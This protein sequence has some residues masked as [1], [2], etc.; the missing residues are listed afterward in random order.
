MCSTACETWC[1]TGHCLVPSH[2]TVAT[3][4]PLILT[5][6]CAGR[7][8]ESWRSRRFGSEAN[9]IVFWWRL[10]GWRP[11]AFIFQSPLR[12]ICHCWMTHYRWHLHHRLVMPLGVESQLDGR[13]GLLSI[14]HLNRDY[15]WITQITCTV[16]HY[17]SAQNLSQQAESCGPPKLSIASIAP[18]SRSN[19]RRERKMHS[20]GD[21]GPYAQ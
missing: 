7:F 12:S 19:R 18:N 20:V 5:C 11:R 6:S 1:R 13:W 9:F 2:T 3:K 4:T 14:R 16:N 10:Q 15:H 8:F 21:C 17:R